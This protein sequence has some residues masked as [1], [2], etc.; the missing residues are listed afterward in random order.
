MKELGRKKS[1]LCLESSIACKIQ[2]ITGSKITTISVGSRID[3]NSDTAKKVKK[4]GKDTLNYF[5]SGEDL[6]K[7]IDA[8]V[9]KIVRQK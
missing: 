5:K 9:K 4:L 1:A 2:V 8:V 3:P 7:D 6:Q